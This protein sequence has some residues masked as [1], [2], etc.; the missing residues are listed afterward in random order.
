MSIRKRY[1]C[2]VLL[3]IYLE[4]QLTAILTYNRVLEYPLFVWMALFYNKP[5]VYRRL[6]NHSLSKTSD[7]KYLPLVPILQLL[8]ECVGWQ[9]VKEIFHTNDAGLYPIRVN[10]VKGLK[11]LFSE[12]PNDIRNSPIYS[13]D[14]IRNYLRIYE[15]VEL[16]R[17]PIWENCR[18]VYVDNLELITIEY[19]R[20]EAITPDGFECIGDMP[21]ADEYDIDNVRVMCK[22]P[23]RIPPAEE[24][25]DRQPPPQHQQRRRRRR[26]RHHHQQQQQGPPPRADMELDLELVRRAQRQ[27][28]QNHPPVDYDQLNVAMDELRQEIEDEIQGLQD[29]E[30]QPQYNYVIPRHQ[31]P[32]DE[33]PANLNVAAEGG[34][35]GE[36][37]RRIE[38]EIVNEQPRGGLFMQ[39]AAFDGFDVAV[40]SQSISINVSPLRTPTTPAPDFTPL[41]PQMHEPQLPRELARGPPVAEKPKQPPRPR[42]ASPPYADIRRLYEPRGAIPKLIQPVGVVRNRDDGSPIPNVPE[43]EFDPQEYITSPSIS[44]PPP[45]LPTTSPPAL[46]SRQPTPGAAAAAQFIL[47]QPIPGAEAAAAAQ[48]LLQQPTPGAEAAAAAAQFLSRQPTP[49]A[50]A[51]PPQLLSQQPTPG[52]E[53]ASAAQFLPR[54]P[55]PGAG[56]AAAQFLSR[57]PTPGAGAEAAAQFLSQQPTP[58]A[59]AAAA[60]FLSRQPTPGAAAAAAQ[61]LSRQPTPGAAAAPPPPPPPPPPPQGPMPPLPPQGPMPALPP[62]PRVNTHIDVPTPPVLTEPHQIKVADLENIKSTLRKI[63]KK[64][65]VVQNK[66]PKFFDGMSKMIPEHIK[67]D[68]KKL[69]EMEKRY[70]EGQKEKEEYLTGVLGKRRSAVIDT[71]ASDED[72]ITDSEW[73]K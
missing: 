17:S 42:P 63:D 31:P 54:Q 12:L 47:Q 43:P 46:H 41:L 19:L 28:D 29:G 48:F 23:R 14:F 15:L 55:T 50:A 39:E 73:E 7:M 9:P 18:Y 51:A 22:S 71:S 27:G 11:R 1:M 61:F 53:A 10:P 6:V 20:I 59:E 72:V 26:R 2:L 40:P 25:V 8:R 52:A 38:N 62:L 16:I 64:P 65:K 30:I 58:G 36:A 69:A 13:I 33:E 37:I 56:A 49:G 67:N 21:I 70:V 57:Q 35:L 68:P 24:A 60:Q 44:P 45:P 3:G 34:I 66:L 4:T 5:S 32:Q